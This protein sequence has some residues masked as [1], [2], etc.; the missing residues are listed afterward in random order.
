M[1]TRMIFGAAALM[2]GLALAPTLVMAQDACIS[3][4]RIFSTQAVDNK[5]ILITDRNK[6]QFTVHMRGVC[7]GMWK[8]TSALGFR[9]NGGELSCISRGDSISYPIAPYSQR[10]TCFVDSV[11]SG[12]PPADS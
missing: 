10:V 5:T 2:S 11:T 8:G 4:K 3:Q 6:N 9:V 1:K 12:P 7:G